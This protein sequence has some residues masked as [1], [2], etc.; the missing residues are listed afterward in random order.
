MEENDSLQQITDNLQKMTRQTTFIQH[1]KI[2]LGSSFFL[3][4]FL[5]VAGCSSGNNASPDSS[6]KNNLLAGEQIVL[7]KSQSCGCCSLYGSYLGKRGFDLKI[8]DHSNL[9]PIKEQLGV[10]ASLQSCHTV[11][12]GNYFVE[13]HIPIEA[14]EKLLQEKPNIKGIAMPGM[15]SGSPGM[16]GAKNEPFVIYAV[17][18]SGSINEFLRI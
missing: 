6:K 10:P 2:F 13:G 15:P 7:F 1:R 9:T 12:I 3:I 5:I 8:E 18:N 11:K 14:I 17:E 16:P 4:F